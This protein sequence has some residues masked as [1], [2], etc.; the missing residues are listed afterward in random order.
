MI[1][2]T[3]QTKERKKWMTVLDNVSCVIFVVSLMGY[4]QTLF[5]DSRQ[6]RLLEAAFLF[7][8]VIRLDQFK[9]VPFFLVFTKK[10]IQTNLFISLCQS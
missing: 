4:A 7:S 5:E 10:G 3:K 1:Y 8:K 6:N 2:F 9:C